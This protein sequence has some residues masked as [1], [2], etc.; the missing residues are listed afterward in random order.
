MYCILKIHKTKKNVSLC[1][2]KLPEY[3]FHTTGNVNPNSSVLPN[4]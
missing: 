2:N 3:I 1:F 4:I